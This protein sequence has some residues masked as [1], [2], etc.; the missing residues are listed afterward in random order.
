[1]ISPSN[2]I[3]DGTAPQNAANLFGAAGAGRRGGGPCLIEP[4]SGALFPQNW[5]RPRFLLAPATSGQDL[6]EI[7]LRTAAEASDL[8]VYTTKTQWTMPKDM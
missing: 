8:V 3:L 5:L 1:M 6:F 7:R 2:P 4:A